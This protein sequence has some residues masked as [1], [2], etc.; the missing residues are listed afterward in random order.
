MLGP[1]SL[2]P[3]ALPQPPSA[4]PVAGRLTAHTPC[5]PQRTEVERCIRQTY[6]QRYGAL[7]P[8]FA[9][10][11]LALR[12]GGQVLAAAGYRRAADGP[13]FLES[14]LAAPVEQLIAAQAGR[15]V[16]RAQI[17][18]VGHLA[19]PRR[20]EGRRL[21]QLLGPFLLH[22]G[23]DWVVGTVTQELQLMLVR[24]GLVPLLLGPAHPDAL[25]DQAQY[26][27]SYY[28]HTPVVLAI[29]LRRSLRQFLAR[30]VRAMTREAT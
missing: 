3:A 16:A 28:Q 23:F 27:G 10:V 2:T 13:L 7:V 4:F 14:Y 12:E 20:G 18:E 8:A 19:A 21:V 22:E 6:A 29:H 26:W 30:R 17:V 9:P 24:L 15:P 25:G 1:S 11:L 5:D